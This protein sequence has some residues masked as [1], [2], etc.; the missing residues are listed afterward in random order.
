MLDI[1]Y[2]RDNTKD[3]IK[4]TE[5]K[6]FDAKVIDKIISV[7]QK[8]RSLVHEVES[9]RAERNKLTKDDIANGK[10][11]K[12]ELKAKEAEL[13]LVEKEYED[14]ML[15][16][17]NPSSLDVKIGTADDNEILRKVGNIK[18]FKFPVRD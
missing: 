18:S 5:A 10:K 2:I 11:L 15:K 16:V 7:D 1:Q 9:F 12:I 13:N 6:G 8:R 14:L 17:P 4:A 3:L